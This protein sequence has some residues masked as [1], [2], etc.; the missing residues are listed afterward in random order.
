MQIAYN[1]VLNVTIVSTSLNNLLL[2][3]MISDVTA[4]FQKF[5]MEHVMLRMLSVLC[6]LLKELFP[7]LVFPCN[8]LFPLP[9]Q[10]SDAPGCLELLSQ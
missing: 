4:V 1:K 9:D 10:A 5:P 2:A 8:L 6:M 3:K 7:F